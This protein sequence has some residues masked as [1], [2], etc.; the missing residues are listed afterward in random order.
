MPPLYFLPPGVVPPD[1]GALPLSGVTVLLVEDSRFAS[2]ALRLMCHRSGARLRRAA[3]MAQ[4]RAHLQMY[5]PD[6]VIIDLG[7]PDGRGDMLIRDITLARQGSVV[8]GLSADPGGRSLALAAGA[9]G[10]LEKPLAGLGAFQRAVMRHL[11][12]R[13]APTLAQDGKAA[14]G[15]LLALHDDLAHAA[16][17]MSLPSDDSARR[18]LAGFV[19]GVARSAGDVDLAH[20]ARAAA[21]AE[22]A[23]PQLRQMVGQRLAAYLSV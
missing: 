13:F 19:A 7:L 9:V 3:T 16:D 22:D 12:G 20:A 21:L 2:D 18:Y 6:V 4:A 14:P 11:P 15:D 8:L 17:L 1:A 23:L 5:H 10:F